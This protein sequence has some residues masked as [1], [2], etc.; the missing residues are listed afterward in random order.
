M[1]TSHRTTGYR[2]NKPECR[3]A[4]YQDIM[5]SQGREHQSSEMFGGIASSRLGHKQEGL[6]DS[7]FRL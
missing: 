4:H 3:Y 2:G 6:C 7:H 5:L 1:R